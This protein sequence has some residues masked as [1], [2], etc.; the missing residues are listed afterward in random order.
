MEVVCGS[1]LVV[2]CRS[3]RDQLVSDELRLGE[4]VEVETTVAVP[5]QPH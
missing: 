4:F 2:A 1:Q 3:A 5:K